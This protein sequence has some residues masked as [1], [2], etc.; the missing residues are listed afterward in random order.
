M[1][2]RDYWSAELCPPRACFRLVVR[3]LPFE[4]VDIN[5]VLHLRTRY[6]E[7]GKFCGLNIKDEVSPSE[8]KIYPRT[9]E[10][11]D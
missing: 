5:R 7:E 8:E 4:S 1:K 3:S 10:D 9:S 2:K 11:K 6:L